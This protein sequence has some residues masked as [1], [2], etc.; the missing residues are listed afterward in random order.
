M[1]QVLCKSCKQWSTDEFNCEHCGNLLN[2][3][4]I[5]EEKYIAKHGIQK[6]KP[7]G[8]LAVFFEKSRNSKNPFVRLLYYIVMGIWGIYVGLV[9][10][11]LYL[12]I[13]AS[14]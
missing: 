3:Q 7:P 8:K 2:E 1:K 6:P 11:M 5:R 12:A 9:V 13:A 10:F 4:I 14:A